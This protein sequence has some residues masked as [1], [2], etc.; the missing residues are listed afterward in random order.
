MSDAGTAQ[1]KRPSILL[2]C[3]G[4][5]AL[6]ATLLPAGFIPRSATVALFLALG[7]GTA[8]LRHWS[9]PD[10]LERWVMN[11]ALSA[12]ITMLLAEVQVILHL[13]QPYVTLAIL[14]AFTTAAATTPPYFDYQISH[15]RP[16]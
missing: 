9:V 12:A 5:L 14:A 11:V 4:W 1:A 6:A 2:A 8:L 3:S 7:P 13:W 16:S 10:P 15:R